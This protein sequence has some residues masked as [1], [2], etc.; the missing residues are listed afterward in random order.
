M[1]PHRPRNLHAL[2][3][4]INLRLEQLL[5]QQSS[6]RVG[7]VV[8]DA[9]LGPGQRLRPLLL[10]LSADECGAPAAPALDLACALE[11]VHAASLVIDDLPAMDDAS[12][13][14]GRPAI[15]VLHGQAAA[16][17]AAIALLARAFAVVAQLPQTGAGQRAALSQQ[18]AALVDTLV[19][20]QLDELQH[21]TPMP[22]P[23]KLVLPALP[24]ATTAAR[25][26]AVEDCTGRK[27]AAAF[28]SAVQLAVMLTPQPVAR[29]DALLD[30]AKHLGHAYQID[31]DLRDADEDI[32]RD[33]Y[34]TVLGR[35]AAQ[36]LLLHHLAAARALL[37]RPDGA[38]GSFAAT[39]FA[40]AWADAA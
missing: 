11:M 37:P 30:F 16:I 39:L 21:A 38:L 20:G 7:V 31:D 18:L 9:V 29:S 25:Q 14:R 34:A 35:P 3:H 32:G 2:R 15:H 10:M 26:R 28:V 13:R 4:D 1:L 17:L 24:P 6:A 36:A 27:T 22:S 23:L 33:T 40:G 12:E 5:D 19:S 8:R